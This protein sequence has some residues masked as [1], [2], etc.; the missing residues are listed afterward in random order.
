VVANEREGLVEVKARAKDAAYM[1]AARLSKNTPVFTPQEARDHTVLLYPTLF[2][3][4]FRY[5]EHT[6]LFAESG[7]RWCSGGLTPSDASALTASGRRILRDAHKYRAAHYAQEL[8]PIVQSL[9][10]KRSDA[11]RA[12]RAAYRAGTWPEADGE[13]VLPP[14]WSDAA[15]GVPLGV[16]VTAPDGT[17][18]EEWLEDARMAMRVFLTYGR[19]PK[20][21]PGSPPV[22]SL[23]VLEHWALQLAE[24]FG[25]NWFASVSGGT[26]D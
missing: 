11:A 2:P 12:L 15:R 9:V 26:R 3:N 7:L 18:N 4:L 24:R 5:Y 21:A 8:R 13:C 14:F 20:R 10:A 16:L 1:A 6:Y 23:R 22:Q 19:D 25:G 17:A